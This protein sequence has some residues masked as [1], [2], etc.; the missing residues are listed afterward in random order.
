MNALQAVE[1]YY[2]KMVVRDGI[3]G[4]IPNREEKSWKKNMEMIKKLKPEIVKILEEKE[5]EYKFQIENKKLDDEKELKADIES[6]VAFLVLEIPTYYDNQINYARRFSEKEK[7]KYSVN[8]QD[9]GFS[10]YSADKNIKISN[11]TA[12]EFVKNRTSDGS[13]CGCDNL[14]YKITQ[15]EKEIILETDK[16]AREA[17]RNQKNL[18]EEKAKAK[19]NVIF[20]KAKSEN[21]R[22]ILASHVTTNCYDPAEDCSF[23]TITEYALP[24]GDTE[25][26]REHCW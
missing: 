2:P 15:A 19:R 18:T 4:I 25:T 7:E 8:F 13:F 1:K 16:I 5:R 22:Q 3:V 10:S 26:K 21:K 11:V 24:G 12:A 20:A 17:T 23:D 14:V 9:R 6:G